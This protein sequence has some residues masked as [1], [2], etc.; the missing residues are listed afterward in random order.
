MRQKR[1]YLQKTI[2]EQIKRESLMSSLLALKQLSHIEPE[3]EE[4]I[5]NI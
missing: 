5:K 1:F 4:M 2:F 3:L